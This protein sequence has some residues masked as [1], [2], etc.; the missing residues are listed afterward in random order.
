MTHANQPISV[1]CVQRAFKTALIESGVK[2]KASVHTLRHS[3]AT[4]LL[5]RGINLRH[6]QEYL[7]HKTLRTTSIYTHLTNKS[8][9]MAYQEIDNLMN[10]LV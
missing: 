6:I 8:K 10:D 2:K 3:Y 5:E 9:Q 7:G 4:H 1:W